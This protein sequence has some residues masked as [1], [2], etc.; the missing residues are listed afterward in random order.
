[1][2]K[3]KKKTNL[4]YLIRCGELSFLLLLYLTPLQFRLLYSYCRSCLDKKMFTLFSAHSGHSLAHTIK[5]TLIATL[6]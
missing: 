5:F 6:I 1:M 3:K 2:N 4:L